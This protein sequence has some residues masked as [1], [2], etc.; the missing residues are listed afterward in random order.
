MTASEARHICPAVHVAEST[1]DWL[2]QSWRLCDWL[3]GDELGEQVFA[4][5]APTEASV[6]LNA[7]PG[8]M[9][10][11]SAD[12][13]LSSVCVS[14]YTA[15]MGLIETTRGLLPGAGKTKQEVTQKI[16]TLQSTECVNGE[17]KQLC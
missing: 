7:L 16:M 2:N 12:L 3:S 9:A 1:H 15:Q 17:T 4:T 10:L 6:R 13:Q 14:A 8:L 11:S 5:V